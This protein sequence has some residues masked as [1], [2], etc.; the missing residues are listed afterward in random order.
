MQKSNLHP[1][2]FYKKQIYRIE[3]TLPNA[4]TNDVNKFFNKK[5]IHS[6]DLNNKYP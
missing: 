6:S 3:P 1:V 2:H 5:G 4:L